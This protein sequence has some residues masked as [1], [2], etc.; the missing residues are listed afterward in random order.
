MACV[1]ENVPRSLNSPDQLLLQAQLLTAIATLA[2]SS[3]VGAYFASATEVNVADGFG[4][5]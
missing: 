5:H 4:I 3:H 2:L 1:P